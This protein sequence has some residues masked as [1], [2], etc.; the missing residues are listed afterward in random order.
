MKLTYLPK[1]DF[2]KYESDTNSKICLDI[3]DKFSYDVT[4]SNTFYNL[5]YTKHREN[6]IKQSTPSYGDVLYTPI[7]SYQ[8][9]CHMIC[10][11]YPKTYYNMKPFKPQ[12]FKKC[13][14]KC[15]K[16]MN[17]NDIHIIYTPIFGT[18]ILEGDWKEI[19][20]IMNTIFTNDNILT[21]R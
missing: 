6:F 18:E 15:K 12:L 5:Y 11:E 13:C 1:S 8:I 21:F 19:L 17:E 16:Y 4:D 3:C 9:I 10:V 20:N 7:F 14:L 2:L